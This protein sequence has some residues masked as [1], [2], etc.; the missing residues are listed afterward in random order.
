MEGKQ[1]YRR[2]SPKNPL[3]R[4]DRLDK[5][6]RLASAVLSPDRSQKVVS[7]VDKIERLEDVAGLVS[8]LV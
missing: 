4:D 7:T 5:F 3:T 1:D 8:L 6:G 2:G